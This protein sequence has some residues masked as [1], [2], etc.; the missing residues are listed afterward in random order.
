MLE[1]LCTIISHALWIP[2]AG[3]KNGRR[4]WGSSRG[5]IDSW[6]S[7]TSGLSI[8]KRNGSFFTYHRFRPGIV[9]VT[10]FA[11]IKPLYPYH[12]VPVHSADKYNSFMTPFLYLNVKYFAEFNA[13]I[14]RIRMQVFLN[15]EEK[16]KCIKLSS[17]LLY[18]ITLYYILFLDY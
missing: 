14:A 12:I 4:G 18:F 7:T 6:P 13:R 1:I 3:V 15:L 8:G 5:R 11:R 16:W 17:Y 10:P 2:R 9:T